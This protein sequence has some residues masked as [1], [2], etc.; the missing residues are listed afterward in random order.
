VSTYTVADSRSIGIN[1]NDSFAWMRWVA[2]LV[3]GGD[4]RRMNQALATYA[5][6][7]TATLRDL[8]TQN[9]QPPDL[10][11]L[12]RQ[13]GVSI[14]ELARM[15]GAS[16]FFGSYFSQ[17]LR[18]LRLLIRNVF[19]PAGQFRAVAH[20]PG[21]EQLLLDY[22]RAVE[23]GAFFAG[24]LLSIVAMLNQHHPDA[25]A[26][27]NRAIAVIRGWAKHGSVQAPPER[28]LLAHWKQWR[29]LAPLWAST[30]GNQQ[31]VQQ[32]GCSP[33]AA[34]LEALLDTARLR[35]TI[36][37]AMWFRQF[38]G[39]FIPGHA[40]QPVV[41]LNVSVEIVAAVEPDEPP[42]APLPPN[43]LKAA[44][45]YRAPTPNY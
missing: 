19:E 3:W 26:S 6:E 25:P 44:K 27:L 11:T 30:I 39:S 23:G 9:P 7:L 15:P 38:A 21:S 10:Q 24:A 40:T 32:L 31:T 20:A 18:N 28:T 36:S 37:H 17:P 45:Q 16:S 1:P 34:G 41:P 43:D 22:K 35:Q 13:M 33:V 14:D 8:S 42:L 12:C 5:A 29:H 2:A 4:P